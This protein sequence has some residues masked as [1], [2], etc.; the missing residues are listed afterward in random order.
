MNAM[1][2]LIDIHGAKSLEADR[3]AQD[4]ILRNNL[5]WTAHGNLRCLT[6]TERERLLGFPV[7]VPHCTNP[8]LRI[9]SFAFAAI[10]IVATHL[11]SR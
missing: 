1:N 10:H 6:T 3:E 9:V 8:D 5:I 7:C 4:L 11:G 2:R